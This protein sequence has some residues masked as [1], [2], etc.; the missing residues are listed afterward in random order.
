MPL[1][2]LLEVLVDNVTGDMFTGDTARHMIGVP[3]GVR[4]SASPTDIP[5]YTAF[6]QSQSHTRI[7]MAGTRFLYE[8]DMGR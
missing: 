8:V 5:G 7:L 6:I 2:D 1:T 4:A 3:P